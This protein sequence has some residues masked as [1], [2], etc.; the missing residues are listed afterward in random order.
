[1]CSQSYTHDA[2]SQVTAHTVG[3]V[4]TSYGYDAF[5]QLTSESRTGYSASYTYDANGN[6]LTKTLGGVTETYAYDSGDK[7]TAITGGSNPRTFGYDA[8]GRTTSVVTG[9][10]TTTLSY[11][12]ESRITSISGPG[13]SASYSYN[14]L[15]TRVSKTENSVD[16]TFLRDGDYVTDPVLSDGSAT[17]TPGISERRGSTTTFSHSGLKNASFQS[18]SSQTVSAERTYDAFGLVVSSSGT[19][20]GPFGYAGGFGYQEDVSGLK[21][22]GHRYYDS[23]TGRFLTR[24][25]IKDGRNW[26]VY[27]DSDPIGSVDETGHF[28]GLI[29]RQFIIPIRDGIRR[30]I[31]PRPKPIPAKT[32][33]PRLLPDQ[34]GKHQ[35]G[36]RN[37]RPGRSEFTHKR[38]QDLI[39]RF[40]GK[41]YPV[42]GTRGQPGYRERVDFGESIGNYVDPK[43]GKPVPTS[44]GIIHYAKDGVHIVPARP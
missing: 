16:K 12:Y 40:A 33:P 29:V 27:C 34:Q 39:D 24:D 21:L 19:W 26:Y 32:A 31:R 44:K 22:L 6:R 3:S 37:F 8:A 5:G 15:D 17:F 7:L 28:R 30:L 23:S 36:H 25:P 18:G 35:P 20:Q 41:G 43:T 10:G 4:T 38:P 11:D 42:A 9:S 2:G 1:M 13:L 14:G